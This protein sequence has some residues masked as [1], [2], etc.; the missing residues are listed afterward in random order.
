MALA[1]SFGSQSFN[2]QTLTVHR[3]HTRAGLVFLRPSTLLWMAGIS[4]LMVPILTLVDV[5]T[6]RWFASDRLPK[7]LSDVLDLCR[8]YSHGSGVFMI[9]LGLIMMA[10]TRRWYVPRL[11]VLAMGGGAIAT[12]T[13]MFVLRPRPDGIHKLENMSY[14]YAW[15]W[16]FDWALTQVATFENKTRAFPSGN[17]ATAIAL[18]VGL[19]MV[20]PRGKGLFIA[21][22]CGTILQRL[23]SGAHFVSDLFGGAA[24]GLL[25][26]YVCFHPRLL[27]SLFDKMEPE[28]MPRRRRRYLQETITIEPPIEK[29][30]SPDSDKIA[31]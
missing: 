12:I 7:E 5:Q 22:C 23:S 3:A 20:L 1:M 14:D 8:V 4:I 28:T 18:S 6:A 17:V 27:G 2:R 24:C 13:K 29:R 25:W 31:A 19:C 15:L 16:E 9:L 10:P 30:R 11:A 26:A 21:I